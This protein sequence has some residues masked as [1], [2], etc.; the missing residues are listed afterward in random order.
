MR[1][2]NNHGKIAQ[3]TEFSLRFCFYLFSD[4]VD[5]FPTCFFAL[6]VFASRKKL[7][8]VKTERTKESRL[9]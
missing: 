9:F 1:I 5:F 3:R 8:A 6:W 2:R 7:A 4:R